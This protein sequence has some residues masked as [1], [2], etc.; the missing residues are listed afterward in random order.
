MGKW[1]DRVSRTADVVFEPSEHLPRTWLRVA[2]VGAILLAVV[3]NLWYVVVQNDVIW[4]LTGLLTF[5]LLFLIFDLQTH[6]PSSSE[7]GMGDGPWGPP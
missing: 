3:G 4:W 1:S 5:P 7:S 2:W 6:H